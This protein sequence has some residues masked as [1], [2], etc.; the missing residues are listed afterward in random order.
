MGAGDDDNQESSDV[1]D[2]N[3]EDDTDD[4]GNNVGIIAGAVVAVVIAAFL[5]G[6][7]RAR[8]SYAANEQSQG[9]NGVAG[10]AEL[11]DGEIRPT[12]WEKIQI[13]FGFP[14]HGGPRPV[15][16]LDGWQHVPELDG[17]EGDRPQ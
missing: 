6:R 17:I 2:D 12:A 15:S 16:E 7:R 5:L 14:R 3:A 4:R 8:R 10:P 9:H 13:A 11:A 1:S